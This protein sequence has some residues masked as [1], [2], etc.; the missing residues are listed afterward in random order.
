MKEIVFPQLK[1]FPTIRI[2]HAACSSGEEVYSMAI[3]LK[4]A[5][6]YEKARI[7][8]SDINED[9]IAHP[10]DGPSLGILPSGK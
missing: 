9:V 8:A 5:G 3:A 4:E 7:F 6:L 10:A 1:D 2:W